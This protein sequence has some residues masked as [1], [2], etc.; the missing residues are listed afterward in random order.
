MAFTA[1]STVHYYSPKQGK[2]ACSTR[3]RRNATPDCTSDRASF[4]AA[5][6]RGVGCKRCAQKVDAMDRIAARI[7]A[8]REARAMPPVEPAHPRD[9]VPEPDFTRWGNSF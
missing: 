7:A 4:R 1:S 9:Y 5:V 3:T 6:A 8:K 2:L